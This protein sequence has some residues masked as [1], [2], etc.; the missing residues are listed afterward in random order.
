MSDARPDETEMQTCAEVVDRVLDSDATDEERDQLTDIWF[1]WNCAP[2][3]PLPPTWRNSVYEH[4]DFETGEQFVEVTPRETDNQ[5]S[6]RVVATESIVCDLEA[7][8]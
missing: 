3:D 4:R 7:W 1:E 2:D 6:E 5:L 8:Q